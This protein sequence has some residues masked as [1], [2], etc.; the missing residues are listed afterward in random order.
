MHGLQKL[1]D[2]QLIFDTKKLIKKEQEIVIEI[3]A[4]LEE[5]E[6]RRLYCDAGY[7]SLWS[8]TIGELG[9]SEAQAHRRIDAMRMSR[10]ISSVKRGLESGT[11]NVTCVNMGSAFLKAA[12]EYNKKVNQ[13]ELFLKLEGKSKKEVMTILQEKREELNL[14]LKQLPKKTVETK[15]NGGSGDVRMHLT[16]KKETVEKIK[17]L[18]GLLAHKEGNL[19]T[20][21]LLDKMLDSAIE[22]AEKE[23]FA[24]GIKAR[25]QSE[26]VLKE[27]QLSQKEPKVQAVPVSAATEEKK[28]TKYAKPL[29]PS[30]VKVINSRYVPNDLK[31]IIYVRDNGKC[32]NCGSRHALEID[33]KRS[34]ALGGKTSLENC[35]LLC[36]S[37]N[38]RHAIKVTG[39]EVMAQYL[40]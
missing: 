34:F 5:I 31:R 20:E 33:H 11:L 30:K 25:S 6:R 17:K 35:R 13:E 38:Q 29:S 26:Q 27:K 16:L 14:P 36:R 23:K 8:Y 21:E 12:S 2:D 1:T 10:K 3:I 7:D 37:C 19:S 32:S 15:T 9:Y 40:R 18:K 24:V 22:K 4:H 39:Q 28:S